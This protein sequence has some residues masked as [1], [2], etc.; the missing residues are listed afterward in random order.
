MHHIKQ[1]TTIQNKYL[2][3]EAQNPYIHHQLSNQSN[4]NKQMPLEIGKI[5]LERVGLY[6]YLK[7]NQ[8]RNE[9][10]EE[11]NSARS[12]PVETR[13]NFWWNLDKMVLSFWILDG[14]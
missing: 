7:K 2:P 1:P 12:E 5:N 11:P 4:P 14:G 10:E 3:Q 13:F 6:Q 9:I 8:P